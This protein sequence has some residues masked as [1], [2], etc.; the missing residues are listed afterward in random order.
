[1]KPF[2]GK[3]AE[4]KRTA[5]EGQFG[6]FSGR[7]GRVASDDRVRS[8]IDRP[9]GVIFPVPFRAHPSSA[10]AA[11]GSEPPPGRRRNRSREG[12]GEAVVQRERG[13]GSRRGPRG[14]GWIGC[15]GRAFSLSGVLA[16][17][18][19]RFPAR[20]WSAAK[21]G[22]LSTRPVLKHGPRSPTR[23][24]V[25]GFHET[26]GR[27]ESEGRVGRPRRD[28]FGFASSSLSGSARP[29]AHRRPV[30]CRVVGGAER[31]RARRDPK[32]GELRLGRAKP[33]ETPVEARSD[34]DVQIDRPTRA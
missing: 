6:R 1:M 31:E 27:S 17:F 26:R 4:P 2:R 22:R 15:R 24:R 23:A 25:A 30:P 32:D 19:I 5:G 16:I 18:R 14:Y 8:F 7:N 11:T 21:S 33:G 13:T 29:R 9:V 34:S 10:R 28:P 12:T 3:R 20:P